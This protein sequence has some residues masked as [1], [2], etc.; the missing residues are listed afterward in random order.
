MP[1]VTLEAAHE[2]RRTLDQTREAARDSAVWVI[3]LSADGLGLV[4]YTWVDAFGKAGAAGIAFGPSLSAPIF[5]RVDG[6]EVPDTMTFDDWTVGPM[7]FSQHDPLLRSRI[8]YQG[9][10]LEMQFEFEAV[11]PPYAY[12]SHVGVF[13]DWF[14]DDRFE[15]SGRAKGVARVDGKE[16]VIDTVC[17]RDRSWGARKWECVSHYKW[18]NF[19]SE[20]SAVHVMDLQ[21]F[22]RSVVRG[23]VF[24]DGQMAEIVSAEFDYDLDPD[25]FHRRLSAVFTDDADRTTTVTMTS[26]TAELAYPISPF[27]T[28]V[29]LVG[30]ADVE[31]VAGECYVEMAWPPEYLERNAR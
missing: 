24:R 5:E 22:G 10:R 1:V 4:A 29:D 30:P 26:V 23:Y 8:D 6:V 17:H 27:L 13:P 19:L 28:L 31:G 21:G 9:E 25:L 11:H 15:Q 7:S 16:Y 12:S 3:P 14:A 18:F 2:A 20:T